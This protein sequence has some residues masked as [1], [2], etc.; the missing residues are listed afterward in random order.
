MKYI[1]PIILLLSSCTSNIKTPSTKKTN[2]EDTESAQVCSEIIPIVMIS[3]AGIYEKNMLIIIFSLSLIL[4]L[5]V[6]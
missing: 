4:Q 2:L 1:L 5:L 3:P 6:K